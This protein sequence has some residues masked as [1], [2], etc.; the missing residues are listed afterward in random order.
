MTKVEEARKHVATC[1]AESA[2]HIM[3]LTNEVD[4]LDRLVG[5]LKKTILDVNERTRVLAV[6]DPPPPKRRRRQKEPASGVHMR[7]LSTQE[8]HAISA[9]DTIP[10]PP[11]DYEEP[12]LCAKG[13]NR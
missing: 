12:A 10:A 13:A 5:F 11:P 2:R 6:E 1:D 8:L 3:W 7:A 4:R 9:R